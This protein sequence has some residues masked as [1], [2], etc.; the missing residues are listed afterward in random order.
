[1]MKSRQELILEE[2]KSRHIDEAY[3]QY[4]KYTKY[5]TNYMDKLIDNIN[6]DSYRFFTENMDKNEI[7][8]VSFDKDCLS[9]DVSDGGAK[10][11]IY[12]DATKAKFNTDKY[13]LNPENSTS[14]KA[15]KGQYIFH[16]LSLDDTEGDQS[17]WVMGSEFLGSNLTI[18]SLPLDKAVSCTAFTLQNCSLFLRKVLGY[19]LTIRVTG[20]K[21]DYPTLDEFKAE[22]I[23]TFDKIKDVKVIKS[24]YKDEPNN[25][26][27]LNK[28]AA[29]VDI[30]LPFTEE[31][32]RDTVHHGGAMDRWYSNGRD[33]FLLYTQ[34][35]DE[36]NKKADWYK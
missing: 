16:I 12:L 24:K 13:M 25:Y 36:I 26:E 29:F 23:A 11:N 9:I 7:V 1:M 6:S 35:H 30:T 10:I 32:A 33:K 21:S 19:K 15:K 14:A 27:P 22:V 17:L 8:D 20:H 2:L 31:E 3:G 34:L 18:N 4:G 5:V 28:W